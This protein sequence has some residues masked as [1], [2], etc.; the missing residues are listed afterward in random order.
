MK[1]MS[2]LTRSVLVLVLV[3]ACAGVGC[4]SEP[5]FDTEAFESKY[6]NLEHGLSLETYLKKK[7]VTFD[8]RCRTEECKFAAETREHLGTLDTAGPLNGNAYA[9]KVSEGETAIATAPAN[10]SIDGVFASSARVTVENPRKNQMALKT[11]WLWNDAKA[12]VTETTG[13]FDAFEDVASKFVL[14]CPTTA[15]WYQIEVEFDDEDD[16]ENLQ[17]RQKGEGGGW[18]TIGKSGDVEKTETGYRVTYLTRNP[19][20]EVIVRKIGVPSVELRFTTRATPL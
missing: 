10:E 19:D 7:P 4:E 17:V 3:F 6:A 20:Y 12:K 14:S 9:L 5:S 2:S 15:C 13:S 1:P 18:P 11:K 16:A 8:A